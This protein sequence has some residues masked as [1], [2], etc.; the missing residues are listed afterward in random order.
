MKILVHTGMPRFPKKLVNPVEDVT[1]LRKDIFHMFDREQGTC[2]LASTLKLQYEREKIITKYW[3]CIKLTEGSLLENGWKRKDGTV[4][5]NLQDENDPLYT[6]PN[7]MVKGCTCKKKPCWSC[8]CNPQCRSKNCLT[9]CFTCSCKDRYGCSAIT[10]KKCPCYHI[11]ETVSDSDKMDS[12]SS[13]DDPLESDDS[14]RNS[15]N[16][17]DNFEY[18]PLVTDSSEDDS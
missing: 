6:I 11:E 7:R 9:F 12:S 17:E 5:I 15:S 3:A 1:R 18:D 2:P 8:E 10:C 14:E 16:F 4:V 13:S